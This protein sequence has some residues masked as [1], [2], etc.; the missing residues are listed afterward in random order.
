MIQTDHCDS[1]GC[2]GTDSKEQAILHPLQPLSA[3]EI[4]KVMSIIS[5]AAPCGENR[6]FETIELMEPP[7]AFMP[8]FRSGQSFPRVARAAV[9]NSSEAV[10]TGMLVS[11]DGEKALS[12]EE[13][14]GKHPRI[15][16]QESL[17]LHDIKSDGRPVMDRASFAEMIVP[18][19]SPGFFN[20][21]RTI[22]LPRDV[23]AAG[24]AAHASM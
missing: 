3:D 14:S 9:Y 12:A 20:R 6:R 4:R 1:S 11:L 5:R 19:G 7:K 16:P 15:N 18:Y 2:S 23:N 13:L 21:N 22:D 24:C 10:L 17:T 8:G